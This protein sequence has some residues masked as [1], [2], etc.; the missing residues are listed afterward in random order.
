M[1]LRTK[2]GTNYEVFG[3]ISDPAVV[4]VHG[5]GLD[6]KTWEKIAPHFSDEYCVVLYDLNG[7]GR[8]DASINTQT[9]SL[10][11]EQLADLLD[12]LEIDRAAIVGFSLGGMINRRFAL[13]YPER[14][15]ALAILN[16]PHERDQEAQRLVEERAV[17]TSAGGIEATI[18]ETLKRW[19]TSSFFE[20]NPEIIS[21]VRN[22]VL[23]NDLNSYTQ[24]RRVLANGVIELIRPNPPISVPTL[25]MTCE[26]DSGS[27]PE[28]AHAISEEISESE[29]V[30]VPALK[31][32]GLLEEPGIFINSLQV[33]LDR[34]WRSLP[35]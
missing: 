33:F 21:K 11:A 24:C 6:L 9:L 2:S 28:M 23:S 20:E 16:S 18:D 13:D 17:Q 10:F 32:L 3:S 22:G 1:A 35:L 27:T 14:T 29:M 4:F 7:H 19:F 26:N 12:E 15:G 30:I 31:H 5:L 8:S 25:I 34:Y